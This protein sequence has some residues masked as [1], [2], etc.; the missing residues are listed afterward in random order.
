MALIRTFVTVGHDALSLCKE[1]NTIF[2]AFCTCKW[3]WP[4]QKSILVSYCKVKWELCA[5]HPVS[6][7]RFLISLNWNIRRKVYHLSRRRAIHID[8]MDPMFNWN[9]SLCLNNGVV[10]WFPEELFLKIVVLFCY[11]KLVCTAVIHGKLVENTLGSI[12]P[13]SPFH[14][15]IRKATGSSRASECACSTYFAEVNVSK[16]AWILTRHTYH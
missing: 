11:R 3:Q 13:A 5:N 15:A 1:I 2:R 6:Y 7:S 14:H 8:T 12:S 4:L 16:G 10:L 9:W